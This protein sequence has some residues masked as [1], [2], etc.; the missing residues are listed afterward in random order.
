MKR[1]V[2]R[3]C[4]ISTGYP[5]STRQDSAACVSLP[6]FSNFKE[7]ETA[8]HFTVVLLGSPERK[9]GHHRVS[10]MRL[11]FDQECCRP[12]GREALSASQRLL[13]YPGPLSESTTFEHFFAKSSSARP[14]S[15]ATV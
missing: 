9:I 8:K 10:P 13:V 4:L 12:V 1:S 3:V 11:L 7:P 5:V 14:D 2:A 6:S 15:R